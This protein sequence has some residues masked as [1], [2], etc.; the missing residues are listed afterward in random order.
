MNFSSV[1]IETE[2][3]HLELLLTEISALPNTEVHFTDPDKGRI[4]VTLEAESVDD[5][6]EEL[7]RIK[8]LPQVLYAEM[9]YHYF[10]NET[11]VVVP[12]PVLD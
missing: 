4:V 8:T 12:L 2:P 7:Q 9:V 5:E 6:V 3:H 10:E 11:E 1:L